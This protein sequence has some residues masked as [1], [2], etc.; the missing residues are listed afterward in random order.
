MP[1][2]KF[3]ICA[4]S[5]QPRRKAATIQYHFAER[6]S[7]G[8]EFPLRSALSLLEPMLPPAG[9]PRAQPIPK[10]PAIGPFQRQIANHRAEHPHRLDHVRNSPSPARGRH[11]RAEQIV[12]SVDVND[13]EGGQLP[14]GRTRRSRDSRLASDRRPNCQDTASPRRLHGIASPCSYERS[15]GRGLIVPSIPRSE[16]KTLTLWPLFAS[17][18]AS[19]R[20][21]TAGPPRSTKGKYDCV[22]FSTRRGAKLVFSESGTSPMVVAWRR[23][24]A[25]ERLRCTE[26]FTPNAFTVSALRSEITEL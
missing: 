12:R 24:E 7:S 17:P 1:A 8:E 13:I 18:R 22:T 19:E 23:A 15:Q 21:F 11:D 25:E 14:C 26:V 6:K 3:R 20:T 2:A 9:P 10:Q 5:P 4:E 16:V